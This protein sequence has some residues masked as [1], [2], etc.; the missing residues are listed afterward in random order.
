[1]RQEIENLK[2]M[3]LG[4]HLEELRLRLILMIAGIFV[5]LII[6][7]GSGMFF[8]HAL[9]NPYDNAVAQINSSLSDPDNQNGTTGI[10]PLPLR[11][12]GPMEGINTYL[13][14]CLFVAV[15]ISSPWVIWQIWAFISAG[16][17]KKEKQFVYA[18]APSSAVLFIAGVLFFIRGVAPTIMKF[19]IK[20]D[21]MLGV[22][23]QWTFHN[24]IN[25]V[26]NLTI[27]FGIVFQMPI[28]IVF[29]EKIGL[30]TIEQLQTTRKFL[31]IGVFFIAAVITPPDP[32]SQVAMAVPLY[33]LY[34]GSILICKFRRNRLRRKTE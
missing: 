3:S 9:Q 12:I 22:V 16:L 8:V 20:F 19:S 10:T 32:F 26:L 5:G 27:M 6:S 11:T 17:Y 18:V 24:Y 25:M 31:I 34:E 21:R 7:F 23:S 2:T 13:K 15:L 30:V 1:M 29:A 14:V 33:A 28:L 4:D